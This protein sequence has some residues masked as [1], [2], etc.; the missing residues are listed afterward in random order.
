VTVRTSVRAAACGLTAL[1]S[2]CIVSSMKVAELAPATDYVVTTPVKAHFADGSVIVYRFGVRVRPDSLIGHGMRYGFLRT[3][4]SAVER[5]ALRDVVAVESF[6][7]QVNGAATFVGSILGIAATTFGSALLAVAIF[8]SCPTVYA[9]SGAGLALQGE[10]FSYSIASLFENRDVDRIAV[11][12]DAHGNLVI[13]LRNEALETH[14]INHVEMLEVRHAVDER[15]TSDVYE[16]P[17]AFGDV[18][19]PGSARDRSGADRLGDIQR[20]DERAFRTASRTIDSAL[21]GDV[22]DHLDLAFAPPASDSAALILRLRNSML[23]TALLY[24]VLLGGRGAGALDWIG[25]D[26]ERIGDATALGHWYATRMGMRVLVP[27]GAGWR[28]LGRVHDT[29]PIAWKSVA[30]VIPVDRAADSLRVRLTFVAD[31]WRIDEIGLAA[32]RRPAVRSLSPRTVSWADGTPDS[33]ARAAVLAP[34]ATY[35]RTMPGQRVKIAFDA[36]PAPR[37][38]TRTYLYASQGYYTEWIRRAWLGRPRTVSSAQSPDSLLR[39][40]LGQWRVS[41]ADYER[42]FAAARVPVP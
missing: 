27:D 30:M 10:S 14:F 15:V 38:G 41:R 34:D 25:T 1:A 18:Q 36:G 9:D 11:R 4:S 22:E 26:L 8:G 39:L 29:G 28:E 16:H 13:E 23:N 40:A 32:V 31:N 42:R 7:T 24:D 17:L 35:L 33:A 21:T 6:R 3:D 19:A 5:V 20:A 2:A 37:A 12:P